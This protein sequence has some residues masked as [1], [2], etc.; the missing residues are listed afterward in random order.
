MGAATAARLATLDFAKLW[1]TR[2]KD[3]LWASTQLAHVA[4]QD[5]VLDAD[6]P[7]RSQPTTTP[8]YP[9]GTPISPNP[10]GH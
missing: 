9:R 7:R 6:S 3:L 8:P 4:W 1:R 10:D 5:H 2:H